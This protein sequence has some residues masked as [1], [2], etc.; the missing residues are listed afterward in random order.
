MLELK[1][2]SFSVKGGSRAKI[3]DQ[4]SLIIKP[5]T[6]TVITGPNGSGK[7]TLAELIMGIKKPTTGQIVLNK[8]DIT[9]ASITERANL[10]LAFSFQQPVKFKGL[11][12]YDLLNIASGELIS[13]ETAGQ[14]LKKVGIEPAEY[15]LREV[16]D[17]LSGGE[18]KRIE[19]ATILA[20]KNAEIIIFDE[21]EAGIDLWSFTNLIKIFRQLKKVG[22]TLIIISHQEKILEIAD[23]IIVLDGG[24]IAKKGA[25]AKILSELKEV[26]S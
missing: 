4:I 1:N 5:K 20:R 2:L 7:S 6:L 19:I 9:T 24:R 11:N 3:L 10:G 25:P 22:K 17:K 18:L 15:L 21:P 12:V 23:E 8:N 26:K 16:N 14:Y 13:P